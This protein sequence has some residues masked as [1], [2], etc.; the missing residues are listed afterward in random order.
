MKYEMKCET[1]L[2]TYT[3]EYC[4]K[5][6]ICLLTFGIQPC[7]LHRETFHYCISTTRENIKQKLKKTKK[8]RNYNSVGGSEKVLLTIQGENR[9]KK[10]IVDTLPL[11]NLPVGITTI[12]AVGVSLRRR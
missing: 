9:N 4:L 5:I 10:S 2:L 3:S 1:K 8:R 11:V 7:D 12:T 6:L